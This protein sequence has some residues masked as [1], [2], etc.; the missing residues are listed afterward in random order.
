M[1]GG[2]KTAAGKNRVIPI[3]NKIATFITDMY[4]Y[5]GEYLAMSKK[6]KK[7]LFTYD[8]LRA[9]IWERSPILSKMSHLPHDGRHTCATLL[10]DADINK[11]TIQL[12]LGHASKDITDRVYTHKTISQLI[13]AINKI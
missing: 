1:L 7:P 8:R 13:D 11:K 6:D 3:A 9:Q 2:M 5:G 10:S 12:I 4:N